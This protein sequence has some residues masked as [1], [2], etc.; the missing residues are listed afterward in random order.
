MVDFWGFCPRLLFPSAHFP[1]TPPSFSPCLNWPQN[2]VGLTC[3]HH[4]VLCQELP[5][6]IQSAQVLMACFAA[7]PTESSPQDMTL[8][9]QVGA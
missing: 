5:A 9:S 6:C 8:S 7:L 2:K 3:V 1:L 4:Q